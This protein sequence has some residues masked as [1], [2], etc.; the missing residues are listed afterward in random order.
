MKQF[1]FHSCL[2]LTWVWV[3][4]LSQIYFVLKYEFEF[5]VSTCVRRAYHTNYIMINIIVQLNNFCII[6][7]GFSE[8]GSLIYEEN[9]TRSLLK[10]LKFGSK[11]SQ[12]LFPTLLHLSHITSD[13]VKEV[14]L[15]E[16]CD[17]INFF[18][19]LFFL[20]SWFK[21]KL[22]YESWSSMFATIVFCLE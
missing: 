15:S 12:I 21:H 17:I 5:W 22:I 8:P 20:F 9:L 19:W 3:F 2:Q 18:W 7:L 14:F 6:I 4:L 13:S 11:E 1:Q 10:A 16:V